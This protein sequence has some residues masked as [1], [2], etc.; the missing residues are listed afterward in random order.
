MNIE[1]I[2][3]GYADKERKELFN[4]P[5]RKYTCLL[6]V[7]QP[8]YGKGA[9]AKP[10]SVKLSHKRPMCFFD[11]KG[12]WRTHVTRL[13]YK[14]QHPDCIT[15]YKIYTNFTF[16][17]SAFTFTEDW[18]SMG[19]QGPNAVDICN[20][21][22]DSKAYHHGVP[23]RFMELL[24]SLPTNNK[25][26]EQYTPQA[27]NVDLNTSLHPE[28]KRSWIRIFE[29]GK[30]WFWQ[31]TEDQRPVYDF[32]KEWLQQQNIFIDFSFTETMDT[33]TVHR[34]R[35]FFGKIMQELRPY[36]TRIQGIIVIEEADTLVPN[37]GNE[38]KPSSNQQLI[39]FTAK[40]PKEGMG[41][42]VLLQSPKQTDNS[43]FT[44]G[45]WSYLLGMY[46]DYPKRFPKLY[47]DPEHNIR[48]FLF[49]DVNQR[50]KKIIPL[51]PCCE[52]ESNIKGGMIV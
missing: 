42:I 1:R 5:F 6:V 24:K 49:V 31:G 27:Y 11:F 16:K 13:N 48:E 33:D 45:Q 2:P 36:Y 28:T 51:E 17:L 19:Y 12:E 37:V 14:S 7:A 4:M 15:R 25:E 8:R 29:R 47:Y 39:N 9:V 50:W 38:Y 44:G 23:D 10:L 3:V 46:A 32:G 20:L 52:Y 40:A 26:F 30:R 34:N 21:F 22:N 18:V 43:I 41:L 35:T